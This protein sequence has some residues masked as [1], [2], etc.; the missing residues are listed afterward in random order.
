MNRTAQERSRV[1]LEARLAT[2]LRIYGP[3][4]DCCRSDYDSFHFS[5]YQPRVA[6][7]IVGLAFL[8]AVTAWEDFLRQVFLG[9]M[10]GYRAKSGYAPRLRAGPASNRTHAVQLLAGAVPPNEADRRCRWNN[11]RWVVSVASIHFRTPNPFARTSE[12]VIKHLEYA[13]MIRN[14]V[15]HSSAKA[16]KSFRSAAN[17]IRH[18]DP[19]ARLPRGYSVGQLLIEESNDAFPSREGDFFEWE[20]GDN[21]ESYISLWLQEAERITP[22]V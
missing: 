16:R 15:A 13:T 2:V 9:Y 18:Q 6:A 21:F 5:Y 20:W 8:D 22:S 3:A 11:F 12:P 7:K 10:C 19:N 1:E 4:R 17:L 14:R